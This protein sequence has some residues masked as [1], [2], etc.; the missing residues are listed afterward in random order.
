MDL[1]LR[2]DSVWSPA[3]VEVALLRDEHWYWLDAPAPARFEIHRRTGPR[4]RS[5]APT[6]RQITVRFEAQTIAVRVTEA[7]HAAWSRRAAARGL[8]LTEWIRAVAGSA[9]G[10]AT[11]VRRRL[12]DC[13][14]I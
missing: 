2:G 7:E 1:V 6:T 9:E 4:P 10:G 3:G 11:G 5:S 8:S 12:N 14:V 13:V